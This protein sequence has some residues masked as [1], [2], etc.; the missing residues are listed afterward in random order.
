MRKTFIFLFFHLLVFCCTS[1]PQSTT[2]KKKELY[3]LSH[4][5]PPVEKLSKVQQAAFDAFNK[6]QVSTDKKNQLYST[7]ANIEHPCYP[8]DTTFEISQIELLLVMEKYITEHCTSLGSKEQNLLIQS[9]ILAQDQYTVFHCRTGEQ[10]D[11]GYNKF[12]MTGIWVFPSV[13][14]RRDILLHW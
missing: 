1:T 11:K 9:S 4:Y 13:L 8:P 10:T 5:Q 2:K 14:G 7:F 6:L 3:S 12:T